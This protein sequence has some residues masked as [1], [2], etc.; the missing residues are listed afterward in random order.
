VRECI[1]LRV[2]VFCG[3]NGNELFT[4]FGAHKDPF[5]RVMTAQAIAKNMPIITADCGFGCVARLVLIGDQ[6]Q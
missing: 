2:G 4:F 5:E 6:N 1:V 3:E